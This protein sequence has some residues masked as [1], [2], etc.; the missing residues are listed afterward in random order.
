MAV[1]VDAEGVVL[2][3]LDGD[4]AVGAQAVAGDLE[5][6]AGFEVAVEE[7][8][9]LVRAGSVLLVPDDASR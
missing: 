9:T 7:G 8:A 5:G 6:A 2:E 4:L 1:E 3:V